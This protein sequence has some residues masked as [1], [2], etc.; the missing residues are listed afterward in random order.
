[1]REGTTGRGKFIDVCF[2]SFFLLAMRAHK[3]HLLYQMRRG[4][5]MAGTAWTEKKGRETSSAREGTRGVDGT[6]KE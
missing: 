4:T 2:G 5:V 3:G 6:F 1:M